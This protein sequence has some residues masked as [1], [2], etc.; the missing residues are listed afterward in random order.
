MNDDKDEYH[1]LWYQSLIKPNKKLLEEINQYSSAENI[2]NR[3]IE[4]MDLTGTKSVVQNTALASQIDTIADSLDQIMTVFFIFLAFL[5][6][7]SQL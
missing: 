5:L 3:A 1:S 7:L 6:V 4:F 2:K